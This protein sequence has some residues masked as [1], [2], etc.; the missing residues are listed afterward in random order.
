MHLQ[1]IT[2]F[3]GFFILPE[4]LG[5]RNVREGPVLAS[6]EVV[7]DGGLYGFGE[8]EDGWGG[9]DRGI[10]EEGEELRVL[11]GEGEGAVQLA[12]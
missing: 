9:E 1:Q 10:I 8:V 6:R 7:A 3:G 5:T 11:V 2:L 12:R 4:I